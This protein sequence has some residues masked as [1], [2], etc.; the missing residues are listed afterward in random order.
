MELS[1]EDITDFFNKYLE[2]EQYKNF[3]KRTFRPSYPRALT[4]DFVTAC[5]RDLEATKA[6]L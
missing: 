3:I 2:S 5:N 1:P 4:Q 6:E